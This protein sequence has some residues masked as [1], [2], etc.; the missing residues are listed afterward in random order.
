MPYKAGTFNDLFVTDKL[1]MHNQRIQNVADPQLDTDA[2]TK[3]YVDSQSQAQLNVGPGL[4][5]EGGQVSL[6]VPISVEHGGTGTD[7]LNPGSLLFG[8]GSNSIGASE[9]LT[10]DPTKSRLQCPS[11][12]AETMNSTQL[13]AM[14]MTG[15]RCGVE[16][17]TSFSVSAQEGHIENLDCTNVN[18]TGRLSQKRV[19]VRID[20]AAGS[21]VQASHL[22]GVVVRSGQEEQVVDLLPSAQELS[23]HSDSAAFTL[24]YVNE[25]T[26]PILLMTQE[27]NTEPIAVAS[28]QARKLDLLVV[29]DK[30]YVL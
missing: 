7:S 28:G 17:V 4:A 22:S 1:D 23:T 18:V 5:Y 13:Y 30:V 29:Q 8:N 26:F 12:Q 3:K 6:K 20:A 14:D 19:I 24:F 2:A 15:V 21:K 27:P 25:G 11:I 9:S 10:W 16:K